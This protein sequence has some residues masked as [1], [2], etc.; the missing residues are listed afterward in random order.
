MAPK[1]PLDASDARDSKK[2]RKG[3]FRVGPDN[4][5]DGPWRRKV[6]KIKKDLIQKAKLKKAYKKIKARELPQNKQSS[7]SAVGVENQGHNKKRDNED[8]SAEEGGEEEEEEDEAS[9]QPD[10]ESEMEDA[11]AHSDN[12]GKEEKVKQSRDTPKS[13]T[14][15][16]QH[17][18]HLEG[19]KN[20]PEEK[21]DRPDHMHPS[22]RQSRNAPHRPGYYDKALAEASKK[23]AEQEAREA[24]FQRRREERERKNAERERFQRAMKKART[25]GR[26]GQRK[27]GRE[28][29]L[30]LEKARRITQQR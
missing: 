21:Q 27:L 9:G 3:G 19:K 26:D 12:E 11:D 7:S 20:K 1:R 10:S 6:T 16:Q 8:S 4:L 29:G 30:L 23:K 13:A 22:R 17:D 5:P 25:P 15:S 14:E 28:S 18:K 2:A 24:E